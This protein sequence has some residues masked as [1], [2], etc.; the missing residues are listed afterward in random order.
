MDR[1]PAGGSKTGAFLEEKN[2]PCVGAIAN[3]VG[4]DSTAPA[5][6]FRRPKTVRPGS[7][8]GAIGPV[9]G[10]AGFRGRDK[11][12]PY[13]QILCFAPAGMAAATRANV[14]RDALIPPDLAAAHVPP[15]KSPRCGG[16]NRPPCRA[17]GNGSRRGNGRFFD[18][19]KREGA[20]MGLHLSRESRQ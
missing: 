5:G 16:R 9:C 10:G 2:A 20:L 11:S 13:E 19:P 6:A 3:I 12:R 18:T 1:R 8:A 14:G 7:Q 15:L 17:T 4:A